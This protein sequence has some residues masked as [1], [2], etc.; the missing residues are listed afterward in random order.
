MIVSIYGV[1]Q[2]IKRFLN[3]LEKNLTSEIEVIL[4]DDGTKDNSGKIADEFALSY[5]E[6]VKVIHKENGGVSSARNKGLEL[7]QGEY[8]IFPDPDDYLDEKYVATILKT[9]EKYNEPDMIFFDYYVG[10]SK[11]DFIINTVPVFEEGIIP[12]EQFFK[13]HIKDTTI[14]G[15]LWFKAIKR[16]LYDGLI[17]NIATKVA[18]DYELLTDLVLKL[19]TIVYIPLPLYYYVMRNNSLTRKADA[20]DIER[21][22]DLS[23]D[24]YQ[25]HSKV[26]GDISNLYLLKMAHDVLINVYT[27][28]I[29]IE[30]EKYKKLI[31]QNVFNIVFNNEFSFNQKKQCVLIWLGLAELYYNW[32]YKK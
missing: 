21:M 32:K 3:S 20:T 28:G 27:K 9:I 6:Y 11:D 17:F 1:E 24:R 15:M 4:V 23:L 10:T 12:K 7:A 13:E 30:T 18:E 14:K 22:Y 29:K 2:Y 5:P 25:K 31:A 16:N 8:V 26:F 19:E